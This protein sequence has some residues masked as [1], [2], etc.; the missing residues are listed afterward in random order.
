[1]LQSEMATR[2]MQQ[3]HK[4]NKGSKKRT[5]VYKSVMPPMMCNQWAGLMAC[6]I[7]DMEGKK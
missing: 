1:M 4:Q 5:H 3:A 7:G 6:T 2:T